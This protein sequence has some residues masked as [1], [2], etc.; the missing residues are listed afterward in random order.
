MGTRG[1]YIFLYKGKYYIF[2]NHFDSYMTGLGA[3][4]VKELRSWTETDFENARAFLD[5]F[6]TKDHEGSSSFKGVMEAL[7]SPQAYGLVDINTTGPSAYTDIEYW[8]TLD[9]DRDHFIV[10][11][12]EY[13]SDYS[14]KTHTQRFRLTAIPEDWIDLTGSTKEH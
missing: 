11:W 7:R 14:A 8:Y 3:D 4:I 13:A 10:Q 1:N 5:N 6:P 2:Y 9:F 12:I